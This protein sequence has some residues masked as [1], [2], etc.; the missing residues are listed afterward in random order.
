MIP[1]LREVKVPTLERRRLVGP[2]GLLR[3]APDLRGA[4]EERPAGTSTGWSSARGTT[5]AGPAATATSS[6]AIPFDSAT[7]KYFREQIQAPWF[8][9]YLKGR[10]AMPL[11]EALTLRGR[12]EPLARAGRPGRPVPDHRNR[13]LY[14]GP[15]A[16]SRSTR[17]T[18]APGREAFDAYVSDP[19]A[20]GAVSQAADPDDVLSGRL[21]VVDLAGR[22]PA[23]RRRPPRRPELRDAAARGGRDDRRR[24]RRASLRLDDRAPTPTGS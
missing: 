8:A 6:G 12:L 20:P 1:Y 22:G 11:P 13:N 17:P 23:V 21:E 18:G 7:A 16:R 9:H 3:P 2:G 24:G 10:G 15:A 19:G 4:R 5:A 14:F